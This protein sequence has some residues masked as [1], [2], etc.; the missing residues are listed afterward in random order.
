MAVT[1]GRV[2]WVGQDRPGKALHPDAEVVDLDGLFVA[3]GFVDTHMHVTAYGLTVTERNPLA[4]D[5]SGTGS[6]AELLRR[7][8][9]FAAA[10]DDAVIWGQGWD[11]T[12]WP[13]AAP[14][15]ADLDAAA[16]GRAVYLARVDAHSAAASSILRAAAG[17]AGL[18]GYHPERPLTAAAHHAVRAAA[19]A[20]L[21][22]QQRTAARTAALDDA[23][24]HGIVAVHE[25]GGPDIF[26][27]DDL[28][29]TA[30]PRSSGAGARLLGAGRHHR[31]A[32][33]RAARGHRGARA[34]R[35]PVRR[36]RVRV[37]HRVAV[38]SRI[39]MRPDAA[40]APISTST[41]SPRICGPAPSPA[42]RPDSM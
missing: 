14:T 40:A 33:A 13:D 39:S 28:Q 10:H 29:R 36:R 37:A 18:D 7:V 26:G 5:L 12:A 21:T 27:V 22:P 17:V 24:A 1:D 9:E 6:C 41:R 25:C 19:H 23:A 35:R 3:P 11:E 38:A 8:A 30:R 20:A 31:G 16:P 32:G 15:T 2:V 4:V 42:S 34:R